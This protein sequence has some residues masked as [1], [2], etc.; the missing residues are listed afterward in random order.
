MQGGIFMKKLKKAMGTAEEQPVINSTSKELEEVKHQIKIFA[1]LIKIAMGMAIIVVGLFIVGLIGIALDYAITSN[2]S[3]AEEIYK[4]IQG[5][6]TSAA[7]LYITVVCSKF[8][9]NIIK[10]NTPFI[11]Q[12]PKGLRKIAAAV[13]VML[14]LSLAAAAVYSGVTGTELTIYIDASGWA[15]VCILMLLSSIFDYGCK[16]QQES[17]ETI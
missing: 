5:I 2:P 10:S 9:E 17:D 11:P 13:I 8:C 16:L 3:V 1:T 14:L 4:V 12:V 6:I 7:I 15:F